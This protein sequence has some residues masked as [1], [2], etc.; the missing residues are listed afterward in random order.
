MENLSLPREI[1]K[2]MEQLFTSLELASIIA[3]LPNRKILK[4][5]R[6]TYYKTLSHLLPEPLC[7]YFNSIFVDSSF[8][9]EALL[10][11]IVVISNLGKD[12]PPPH[13]GTPWPNRLHIGYWVHDNTINILYWIRHGLS[14][15][16]LVYI[17]N[18]CWEGFWRGG[19]AIYGGNSTKAG[20]EKENGE[21]DLTLHQ[22]PRAGVKVNKVLSQ[23]FRICNGTRQGFPLSPLLFA[24]VMEDLAKCSYQECPCG[25]ERT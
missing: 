16:P 3:D 25:F 2:K 7:N 20:P 22:K 1:V 19:L 15:S 4:P 10:A 11:H 9:K 5:G 17:I 13:G 21:L 18:R 8:P 14:Q 6:F 12:P 24:L 23:P